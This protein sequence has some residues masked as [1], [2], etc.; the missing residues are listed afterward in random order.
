MQQAC[1]SEAL[2]LDAVERQYIQTFSGR[3]HM[4]PNC[5]PS[6]AHMAPTASSC[7][8][9]GSTFARAPIK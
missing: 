6:R 4:A 2:L 7:R 5:S 1:L 3:A 9:W 8:H